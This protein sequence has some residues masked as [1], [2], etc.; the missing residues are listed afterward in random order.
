M[1]TRLPVAWPVAHRS[2]KRRNFM[3]S[4]EGENRGDGERKALPRL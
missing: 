3:A 1:N 4:G 2:E